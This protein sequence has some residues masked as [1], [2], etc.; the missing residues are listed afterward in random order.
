LIQR[1]RYVR[2]RANV[3]V[4]VD[5][6]DTTV[7]GSTVDVSEG[8]FRIRVPRVAIPELE[9]TV[10]RTVIGGARVALPGYVLR[11]TDVDPDQTEAVIAFQ[12]GSDDAEA[13]R[14]FVLNMRL[15]ARAND[16]LDNANGQ[17][18]GRLVRDDG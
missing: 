2:V 7:A 16:A 15:R 18:Q 4:T 12:A 5:L 6:R 17:P 1:R 8:G 10:I 14:R 9:R 13:V 3:E 11:T